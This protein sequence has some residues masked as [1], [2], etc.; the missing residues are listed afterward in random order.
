MD[1]SGSRPREM[2]IRDSRPFEVGFRFRRAVLTQ[3]PGQSVE[4]Y[5]VMKMKPYRIDPRSYVVIDRPPLV[6]HVL[7][8]SHRIRP[9]G[10]SIGVVG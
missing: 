9:I 6:V 2:I 5:V 8:V 4:V 7:G 1:E 10:S 3:H